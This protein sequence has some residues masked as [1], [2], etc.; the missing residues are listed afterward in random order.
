M[1]P[2]SNSSSQPQPARWLIV[3]FLV[4]A[5]AGFLDSVYLAAEYWM[6]RTVP[7]FIVSGCSTVLSSPYAKLLGIP[8]GAYG[9]VYY[10]S[11]VILTIAFLDTGR[12]SLIELAARLSFIGTLASAVFLYIQIGIL[13]ALCTYCT[14]S[15]LFCFTLFA[16]GLSILRRRK[17]AE[18]VPQ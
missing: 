11:L 14:L 3:L 17:R 13:E 9:V 15:A 16:L 10:L 4:L 18:I 5:I 2:S 12:R 7:C 6:G 1:M 8:L